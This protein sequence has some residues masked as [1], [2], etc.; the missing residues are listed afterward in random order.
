MP[1]DVFLKSTAKVHRVP[2]T[3]VYLTSD[4]DGVPPALLHNLKN[5][6]I[7]HERIYLVTVETALTPKVE[8]QDRLSVNDIGGGLMRIIIR[9]GFAETTRRYGRP[10]QS[11]GQLRSD[12]SRLF[13]QPPDAGAIAQARDGTLARTS[14]TAMVR[15]SETP[16]SFFRLP[17]NRVVELGSQIEI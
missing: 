16:M 13:P 15:N 3:A 6:P 4:K 12:G 1:V 8:R 9:Y 2:A 5:N 7:L 14:F 11:S 10:V 17:V